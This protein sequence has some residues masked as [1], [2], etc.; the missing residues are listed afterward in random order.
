[1]LVAANRIEEEPIA[2]ESGDAM[3]ASAEI[4]AWLARRERAGTHDWEHVLREMRKALERLGQSKLVQRDPQAQ[5]I[6]ANLARAQN[7][8]E[9]AAEIDQLSL[10]VSELIGMPASRVRRG[11][12]AGVAEF[13][14]RANGRRDAEPEPDARST[15]MVLRL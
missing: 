11:P 6:W 5:A 15:R 3:A 1:L 14:Q 13:E 9:L 12:V 10:R 2:P 7:M 8:A 4:T